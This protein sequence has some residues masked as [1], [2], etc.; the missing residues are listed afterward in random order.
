LKEATRDHL[1]SEL[2]ASRESEDRLRQAGEELKRAGYDLQVPI[3]EGATN[4]FLEGP[5]GRERLLRDGEGFYLRKSGER[6]T[7]EEIRRRVS[8]DPSVLSPN[9]LLRP[10]VEG[11]FLPTLAYV[12]GPGEAAY[13]A[14]TAH[15]F[16]SHGLERPVVFPRA[17]LA[18]VEGKVEKVL[19]KYG[20]GVADLAQPFHE[21]AG[22]VVR[23]DVPEG[24]TRE[25]GEFRGAVARHAGTLSQAIRQVD[26]TLKGP[27]EH[28][29][30]QAVAGL[31]DV[32][33]KV[34]QALKRENDIALAQLRKAQVHLYPDGRPQE[35]VLSFWYYLFRYGE[36]LLEDLEGEARKGTPGDAA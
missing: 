3:I 17:S 24:L 30:N 26:P 23:E 9:V 20:L 4:L 28:V 13:L 32:E 12:A 6:W 36:S 10:V 16:A 35:R 19:E 31:D 25:L 5:A 11:A 33:R 27:V 7:L 14:E 2:E 34:V 21:L 15:L 8:D 29:R 1:L 22:E 18:L